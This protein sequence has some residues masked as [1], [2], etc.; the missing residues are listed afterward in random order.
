MD[1]NPCVPSP[2]GPNSVCQAYG[3][4]P[5]CS[6][7][8]NYIGNPPNCRPECTIN[9]ECSS[10][11]ACIREKCKDPCPGSCGVNAQCN[12][13]NHVPVCTCPEGFTGDPFSSCHPKPA[14]RKNLSQFHFSSQIL[15]KLIN[16]LTS[17]TNSSS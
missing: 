7:L 12:V 10:N 5:S 9:S 6:C 2:C 1:I 17:A 8:P 16:Y 3:T 13:F 15:T 14:P 4:T 11:L